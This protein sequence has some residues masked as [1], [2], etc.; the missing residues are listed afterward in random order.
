MFKQVH[1]A[2]FLLSLKYACKT[3]IGY[4]FFM[5]Y[6][7]NGTLYQQLDRERDRRF[8]VS[9]AK[10]CSAEIVSAIE[11]LHE[12]HIVY[13]DLKLENILIDKDGHLLLTDFGLAGIIK[14]NGKLYDEAGTLLY[15]PPGK[16]H[17][18]SV[19]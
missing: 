5:N 11:F 18:L 6:I 8:A 4:N 17:I 10:I 9:T 14:N 2:P 7:P 12:R 3:Q 16:C 13:R 15:F 19:N 1:E